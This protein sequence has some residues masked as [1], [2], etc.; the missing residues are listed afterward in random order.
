MVGVDEDACHQ[1]AD[2]GWGVVFAAPFLVGLVAEAGEQ[3]AEDVSGGAVVGV[4][5]GGEVEQAVI[6]RGVDDGLDG[7]QLVLGGVFLDPVVQGAGDFDE[8]GADHP[9]HAPDFAEELR[10]LGWFEGEQPVGDE[11]F[12]EEGEGG[13]GA[14]GDVHAASAVVAEPGGDHVLGDLA[15]EPVRVGD[16][17][18]PPA[19]RCGGS[20]ARIRFGGFHLALLGAFGELLL[21]FAEE[22]VLDHGGYRPLCVAS[23]AGAG[24]ALGGVGTEPVLRVVLARSMTSR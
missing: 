20:G 24:G 9:L 17:A 3:G 21:D 4:V 19:R 7:A 8:V 6:D 16:E 13:D 5:L 22:V 1:V 15:G 12:A 14:E 10:E 11:G 18:A 23:G 2:A